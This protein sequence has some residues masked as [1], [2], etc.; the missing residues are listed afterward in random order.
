MAGMFGVRMGHHEEPQ[1]A[2]HLLAG[3]PNGLFVEIFPDR[4]RDPM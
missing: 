3:V 1:V 4:D 2:L